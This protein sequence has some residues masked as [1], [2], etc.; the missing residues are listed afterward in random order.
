MTLQTGQA[1]TVDAVNGFAV[2]SN[3]RQG[4]V[5]DCIDDTFV[6]TSTKKGSPVICGT[7]TGQHSKLISFRIYSGLHLIFHAC[8]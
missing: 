6:V 7:N 3:T 4:S 5:G 1:A 8:V 2:G